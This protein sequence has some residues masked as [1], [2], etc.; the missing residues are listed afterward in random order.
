[1]RR[2]VDAFGERL[3]IGEIYLP[4]EKLV[5]YYGRD[6]RG[7]HLPFNFSLLVIDWQARA[8]A[9]LVEQYESLLPPGGW[10]NWVLGNHDRPRVATRIGR[11]QARIAAML[12]LTLRGTPT[13][14]YGDEIGMVQVPIPPERIQDP[15]GK[16]VP[17]FGLGRDGARTPMQWDPSPHAGFSTAEPWLPLADDFRSENVENAHGDPASLYHLYRRL[18]AVRRAH[19]ALTRG[20][21]R[22]IVA[23]NDLLLY[24]RELHGGPHSGGTQSRRRTGVPRFSASTAGTG[25]RIQPSRSRWRDYRWPGRVASTR[26]AGR[27]AERH[28]R[29]D[30]GKAMTREFAGTAQ[31]QWVSRSRLGIGAVAGLTSFSLPIPG[32]GQRF[33]SR[34]T[35]L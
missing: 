27:R 30:R 5:T 4:L 35:E 1:M 16:N 12:L 21:Y 2:V 10:P 29:R 20:A 18:I 14:Y 31:W 23:E 6:L 13:I 26:R 11:G 34:D 15:F 25:T 3:L 32:R 24:T 19:P 9:R 28:W 8:I 22:P 7:C 17:G 33:F